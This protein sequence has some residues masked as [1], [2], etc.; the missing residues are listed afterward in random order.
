M[1]RMMLRLNLA[2]DCFKFNGLYLFDSKVGGNKEKL[3]ASER[4]LKQPIFQKVGC[5]LKLNEGGNNKKYTN[6]IFI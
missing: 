3:I 4:Y 1:C 5:I 2:L 6:G